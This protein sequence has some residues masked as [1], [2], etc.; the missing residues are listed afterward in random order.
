MNVDDM[1]AGID[2]DI[3]MSSAMWKSASRL[4]AFGRSPSRDISGAWRILETNFPYPQ[5]Y[6]R[7]TR[8]DTGNWRCDIELNG[9]DGPTVQGLAET[10]AL[11]ICRAI[12]HVWG[13]SEI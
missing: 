11:A 7:L 8:T 6:V 12:L 1:Q 9:G 13:V 2:M 3:V 10:A 4:I 5:Y